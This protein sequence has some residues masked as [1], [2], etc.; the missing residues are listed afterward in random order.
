LCDI[1]TVIE[2]KTRDLE[3]VVYDREGKRGVEH[4]LHS[5]LP[6]SSSRESSHRWRENDAQGCPARAC[7]GVETNV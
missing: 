7:R 1:R 3:V 4:L 6:H 5:G 2:K